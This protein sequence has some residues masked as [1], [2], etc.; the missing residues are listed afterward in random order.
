MPHGDRINALILAFK[1]QRQVDRSLC[2]LPESSIFSKVEFVRLRQKSYSPAG[3]LSPV[4]AKAKLSIVF[5]LLPFW[6]GLDL[7]IFM[8]RYLL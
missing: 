5:N 4:T 3:T 7:S 6:S 2:N 1:S 8:S